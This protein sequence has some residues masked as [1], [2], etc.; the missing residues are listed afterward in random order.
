MYIE[1]KTVFFFCYICIFHFLSLFSVILSLF[2][3]LSLSLFSFQFLSLFF[4]IIYIIMG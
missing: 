4:V 1:K 2:S 3:L